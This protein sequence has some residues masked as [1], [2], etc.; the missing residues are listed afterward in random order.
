MNKGIKLTMG[1]FLPGVVTSGFLVHLIV[2]LLVHF[3]SDIS[4]IF[5]EQRN[6][7]GENRL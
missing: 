7:D 2:G 4:S 5:V 6:L 3:L 1:L